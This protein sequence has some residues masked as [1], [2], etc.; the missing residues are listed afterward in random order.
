[1]SDHKTRAR[2]AQSLIVKTD[3]VQEAGPKIFD[4]GITVRDEFQYD[5]ARVV[6][7]KI[8]DN[9]FLVAS[10]H[11][12]PDGMAVDLRAPAADG[13]SARWLDL[14]DF[15]SKITEQPRTVRSGNEMAEFQHPDAVKRA[16]IVS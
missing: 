4:D 6:C 7:L 9:G 8:N 3:L 2:S 16:N 1:M 15:G 12:P 11:A 10:M 5:L 14:D 13:I